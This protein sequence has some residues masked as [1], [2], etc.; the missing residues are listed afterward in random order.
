MKLGSVETIEKKGSYLKYI[1]ELLGN[2]VFIYL[3]EQAAFFTRIQKCPGFWEPLKR[4]I[5]VIQES[6]SK[7]QQR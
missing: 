7:S 3:R 5:G 4:I 6:L 1:L 2:Q